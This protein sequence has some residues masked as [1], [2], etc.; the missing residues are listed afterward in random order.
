MAGFC[1]GETFFPA[2]QAPEYRP[3]LKSGTDARKSDLSGS[4][5]SSKDRHDLIFHDG[6]FQMR[7]SGQT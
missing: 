2:A 7:N 1:Q 4:G 3:Q 6:H 5:D